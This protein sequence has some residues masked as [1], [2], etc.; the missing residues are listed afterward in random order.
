[1]LF[2][3]S[4]T[5]TVQGVVG[6]LVSLETL[7]GMA[8]G[9]FWVLRWF[10]LYMICNTAVSVGIGASILAGVDVNCASASNTGTCT[11]TSIVYALSMAL[12]SS[13]VGVFAAINSMLVYYTM[14]RPPRDA[15][16]AKLAL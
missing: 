9:K 10:A 14:R 2:G 4:I 5:A 8:S 15:L 7:A 1:M 12:G 13:S 11:Q 16:E 3:R 6:I